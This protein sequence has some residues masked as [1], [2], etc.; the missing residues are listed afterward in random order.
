[1]RLFSL[2]FLILFFG[3]STFAQ[4]HSAH[5]QPNYKKFLL[6]ENDTTSYYLIE[7]G[8]DCENEI[9]AGI[10]VRSISPTIKIIKGSHLLFLKNKT[11]CIIKKQA[12]NNLW[13]YSPSLEKLML[14]PTKFREASFIVSAKN[15]ETVINKWNNHKIPFKLIRYHLDEVAVIKCSYECLQRFILPDEEIFFIDAYQLPKSEIELVGYDRSLNGINQSNYAF[16]NAN[17]KG[18]TIGIKENLFNSNDIDL[19]KRMVNSSIASPQID[20]H[21]TVVATLAGGAGNSSYMGRGLAWQCKFYPS[22]FGNLFPDATVQL[23]Q[24]NVTV[25]NHSYGT[26]VQNFYGAEA[27]AYDDQTKQLAQLVHVFSSGNAGETTPINGPYTGIAGYSN[28]TGNFKMA[29]NIITVGATDT[30]GNMAIFSSSGPL[31]D[32]RLA[33]QITALGLNGT[34]DAAAIVSGAAALIQQVYKDSNSNNLPSASLVKAALFNS[35]DLNKNGI[36]YKTGFGSLNAFNAIKTLNKRNYFE[37]SLSTNETFNHTI[38]LTSNAANLK[39]TLCWTDTATSVNNNKALVNDLDVEVTYVNTGTVFYPWVLSSIASADSLKKTAVR[40][41]D[42]LNT[43]EQISVSLPASGTYNIKVMAKQVSTINKQNFSVVYN[44]DTL[45]KLQF[46]NPL[47]A[48]DVNRNE[49]EVLKIKW[50]VALADTTSTGNLFITYDNGLNWQP[51]AAN[52]SLKN[53]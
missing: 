43:A 10:I 31:Y 36:S 49:N 28:I 37:G 33:P 35:A 53:K 24:S 4:S 16:A 50:T 45:N 41:R 8:K 26:I 19:Q 1:M 52:I 32:G 21:A 40:R 30:A 20:V 12:A 2:I 34:S 3:T 44:W 22:T 18:I 48:E 13:K 7:I 25:Q 42:S 11:A 38:S 46:V 23:N 5:D 29:K 6:K 51:I 9:S 47:N 15:I 17:G 14:K 39:I 27:K